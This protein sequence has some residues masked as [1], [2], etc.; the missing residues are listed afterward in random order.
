MKRAQD[1]E[2]LKDKLEG[3]D[4]GKS[5]A[6]AQGTLDWPPLRLRAATTRSRCLEHAPG[7]FNGLLRDPWTSSC[8]AAA[9]DAALMGNLVQQ[10]VETGVTDEA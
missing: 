8:E 7:A 9:S 6:T 10:M 4:K 2:K 5:E 3:G 1:K